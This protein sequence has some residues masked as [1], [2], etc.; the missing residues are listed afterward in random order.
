M[1][2]L[3]PKPLRARV[4]SKSFR[5]ITVQVS[6]GFEPRRVQ[7]TLWSW[8]FEQPKRM[9]FSLSLRRTKK[10]E[11]NKQKI[12]KNVPRAG[13]EPATTRSSAERS[14]RLSYLGNSL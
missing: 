5:A 4:E 3:F 13:F 8:R 14:P 9:Y 10:L 6:M 12:S 2:R 7:T 11:R 1:G